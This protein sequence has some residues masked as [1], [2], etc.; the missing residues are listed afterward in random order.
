MTCWSCEQPID[1]TDISDIPN[2]LIK[3]HGKRYHFHPHCARS[4]VAN[5]IIETL[6]RE[7]AI[8]DKAK[9]QLTTEQLA[10]KLGFQ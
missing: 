1:S 4:I 2:V 9:E 7:Q 3:V 6:H 10:T 8:N 5:C